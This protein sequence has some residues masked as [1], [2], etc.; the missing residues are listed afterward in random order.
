MK[1][2]CN[3]FLH[4]T[5]HFPLFTTFRNESRL[6]ISLRTRKSKEKRKAQNL[7]AKSLSI[8]SPITIGPTSPHCVERPLPVTH[9]RKA[10]ARAHIF[11]L[12][13]KVGRARRRREPTRSRRL[14]APVSRTVWRLNERPPRPL[15]T[16]TQCTHASL[17]LSSSWVLSSGPR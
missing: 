5:H 2:V 10:R 1:S 3:T 15:Y 12:A 16:Y 13:P 11:P 9:A 7:P 4:Q 6:S 14:A 17:F 8:L